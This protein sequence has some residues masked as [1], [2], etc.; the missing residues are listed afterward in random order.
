MP[1]N[2]SM[3]FDEIG[4]WS[5]LKLEIVEKYAAAYS[6]IL[7]AQASPPLWHAY[8]DAFAGSGVHISRKT[9]EFVPG[10]PLNALWVTP[11]FRHFFFIDIDR[12]KAQRLRDLVGA[13]EDVSIE[14]GDA[15]EILLQ[16]VFPKVRYENYCRA[17]CLLDPYGLH[18]DW[19]V[20]ATAGGMKSV[21]IF[22]NFPVMDMNRNAL[23]RDPDRVSPKEIERMNRFWGDESWHDIAYSSNGMLFKDMEVKQSNEAVVDQF[24]RRLHDVA[25]FDY[26]STALPMQ[27][28]KGTTVYYLLLASQKA[29]ATGIVNDIF[30]RYR[31]RTR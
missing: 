30:R 19:Q 7:S 18:L 26:V 4:Y 28:S 24:R 21:D 12:D 8:I 22:L 27:N 29:V 9:G 10:S 16:R 15:S 31:K 3:Q 20:L 6:T 23:W 14:E 17:L 2:H 5:E 13:R 25:G 1:E 11:P